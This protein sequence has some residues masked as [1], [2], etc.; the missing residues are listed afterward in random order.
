MVYFYTIELRAIL[1]LTKKKPRFEFRSNRSSTEI[2]KLI[3]EIK[4]SVKPVWKHTHLHHS[5]EPIQ[6][7]HSEGERL[8]TEAEEPGQGEKLSDLEV[9]QLDGHPQTVVLSRL[10]DSQAT[11][12]GLRPGFLV[13]KSFELDGEGQSAR[14][15]HLINH[16]K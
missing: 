4:W 16:L 5:Q 2:I 15:G 9:S 7:I 13:Q 11:E 8:R 14:S 1:F 12:F 3:T 6:K 10:D